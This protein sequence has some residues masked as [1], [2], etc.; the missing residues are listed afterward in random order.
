M[1]RT[2][3]ITVN[4]Y[5][6]AGQSKTS[7]NLINKKGSKKK[8]SSFKNSKVEYTDFE[9]IKTIGRGSVGK[10]LLVK[11]NNTGDLYV[12]KSMRKDQ[13]ISEDIIDNILVERNILVES[14]C[15]FI[16]TLSF[17]FQTTE[18]L[19]FITPFMKG[20]DLYHRLKNEGY[21]KEDQVKLYA[22]QVA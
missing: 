13:L 14:Q 17:F 19:Y 12:M 9:I 5:L 8:K 1:P 16:L 20:G 21:I 18:R 10:I 3:C 7:F 22:A 2:S 4:D 6:F 15:E 11:Y